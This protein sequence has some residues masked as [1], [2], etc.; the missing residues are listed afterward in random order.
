M[1]RPFSRCAP[2]WAH[3][4]PR[5]CNERGNGCEPACRVA[6]ERS[7]RIAPYADWLPAGI[8]MCQAASASILRRPRSPIPRPRS[9]GARPAR[10]AR[11]ASRWF[12]A[13]RR[14]AVAR[15]RWTIRRAHTGRTRDCGPGEV[16]ALRS[17]AG[18]RRLPW[19]QPASAVAARARASGKGGFIM[20]G[21]VGSGLI[22]MKGRAN[23]SWKVRASAERRR[24]Y[25]VCCFFPA[26]HEKP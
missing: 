18:V 7:I 25:K 26:R 1:R 17:C 24:G 12:A 6:G 23:T 3:F 9:R 22:M 2:A 14:R 19:A 10:R 16:R 20:M 5:T 8:R 13:G 21:S 4:V 15:W 11:P